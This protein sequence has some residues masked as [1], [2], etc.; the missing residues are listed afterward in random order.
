MEVGRHR[1]TDGKNDRLS[2]DR[3]STAGPTRGDPPEARSRWTGG[4]PAVGGWSPYC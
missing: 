1:E 2:P 3:R 4:S